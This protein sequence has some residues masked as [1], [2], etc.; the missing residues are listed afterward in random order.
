[1]YQPTFG[2]VLRACPK[3]EIF[4]RVRLL[5]PGSYARMNLELGQQKWLPGL[6]MTGNEQQA[7]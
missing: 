2:R 5:S 6:Q 3:N 7:P 4:C 1:M